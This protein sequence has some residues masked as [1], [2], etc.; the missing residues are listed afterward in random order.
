[1]DEDE[2]YDGRDDDSDED[3]ASEDDEETFDTVACPFCRKQI[4][5]DTVRCPHCENYISTLDGPRLKWQPWWIMLGV[6]VCLAIA[7]LWAFGGV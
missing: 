1:M 4:H 6:V 7:L 2:F 5:E 3:E